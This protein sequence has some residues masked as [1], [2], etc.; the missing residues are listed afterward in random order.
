[1]FL[2]S[3]F[4]NILKSHAHA[5]ENQHSVM[6]LPVEDQYKT[7]NHFLT[8]MPNILLLSEFTLHNINNS[9]HFIVLISSVQIHYLWILH[10]NVQ[11]I[12]A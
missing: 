9:L 3:I 10:I 8:S 2:R 11:I 6:E 12:L 5:L 7:I 4:S 1:M